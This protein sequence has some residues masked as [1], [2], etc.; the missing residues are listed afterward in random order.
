MKDGVAVDGRID[1]DAQDAQF[2]S[3]VYPGAVSPTSIWPLAARPLSSVEQY[4]RYD[5][6]SGK[7]DPGYPEP[8]IGNWPGFP[9]SFAADVNAAV[10]WTNGK[11]YCLVTK[12][13]LA[14]KGG[15]K[16]VVD[17]LT[18]LVHNS[19]RRVS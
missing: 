6:K 8:I 13:L 19:P 4:D 14:W 1:I 17:L 18:P 12:L 11:A 9:A 10:V 5:P 2:A 15:D 16:H 3:V 7:V